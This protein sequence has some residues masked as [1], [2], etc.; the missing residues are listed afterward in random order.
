MKIKKQVLK[1]NNNY[2]RFGLNRIIFLTKLSIF[3]GSGPL[4]PLLK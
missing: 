3:T 2:K 1:I 4:S